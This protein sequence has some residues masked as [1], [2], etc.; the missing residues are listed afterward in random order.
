MNIVVLGNINKAKELFEKTADSL[1]IKQ[2]QYNDLEVI[3]A[4]DVIIDLDLHEKTDNISLYSNF[5]Q[6]T[7]IANM[8]KIQAESLFAALGKPGENH[9]FSA[10]LLP[11]FINRTVLELANPL[12]NDEKIAEDIAAK[13]G[14]SKVKWVKSRVGM[15][16]PRLVFMII[17]EAYYTLQ[18]GTA[19]AKDIDLGMKLGTNY[20]LGPFEWCKKVGIKDVYETLEAL[21]MDTHD[22]RYKVCPMLKT[23]Y[24]THFIK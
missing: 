12:A 22:E 5:K 9:F 11:T 24:L 1:P 20:P 13:L 4:A 6:K 8:V 14:Y 2:A 10:N 21:Y 19:T 18:E 23:E 15:V 3:G 7:I 16:T 17:N